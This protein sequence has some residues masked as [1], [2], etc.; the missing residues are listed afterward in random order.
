MNYSRSITTTDSR[1]GPCNWREV[2]GK[3]NNN[4]RNNFPWNLNNTRRLPAPSGGRSPRSGRPATN[5]NAGPT[6]AGASCG[7]LKD[8]K[9]PSGFATCGE[10]CDRP[11]PKGP[12][13]SPKNKPPPMSRLVPLPS[14]ML[15]RDVKWDTVCPT[16]AGIIVWSRD[17]SAGLKF[18]L[19]LDCKSG[20]ITDF[21]GGVS[22][23]K[24]G[25]ALNGALRE[26][27]E[28]SHGVFG[29]FTPSQLQDCMV[30]YNR[31]MLIIFLR[32]DNI[33]SPLIDLTVNEPVTVE[34]GPV[35]LSAK[36][37]SRA[38][39]RSEISNLIWVD[40]TEFRDLIVT[41]V[42]HGRRLYSRV[43]NLLLHAENFLTFLA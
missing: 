40:E 25:S 33:M 11:A 1:E 29:E 22:Y 35:E 2:M 27:N 8:P 3:R 42:H 13:E 34:P 37:E 31:S 16:R 18:C 32:I 41:G 19:G 12:A 43:R 21:G 23:R 4:S 28:E 14:R 17:S 36:F 30:I 20:D 26:F 38:T 15:V 39:P 24:D 9:G 7:D 5:G 10:L 6:Y